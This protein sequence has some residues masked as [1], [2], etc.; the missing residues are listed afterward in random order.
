[1]Q[2]SPTPLQI[3]IFDP[4]P[5]PG[6]GPNFDPDESPLC[7]LNIPMRDIDLRAPDSLNVRPLADWLDPPIGPDDF[8]PRPRL[9]A[10][11]QHRLDALDRAQGVALSRVAEHVDAVRRE[12]DG[13]LVQTGDR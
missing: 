6:A 8:P 12:G 10:Y 2:G 4:F 1:M 13:W 9:G 7:R 11:I 5:A 3:D